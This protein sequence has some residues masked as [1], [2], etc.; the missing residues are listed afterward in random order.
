VSAGVIAVLA[1]AVALGV[2]IGLWANTGKGTPRK[3]AHHAVA[4]TA[5]YVVHYCA[6]RSLWDM[7]FRR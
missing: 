1:A 7:I 2:V 5:R 3:A 6:A 4:D